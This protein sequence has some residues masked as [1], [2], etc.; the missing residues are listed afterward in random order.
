MKYNLLFVLTF[1][2][3]QFCIAQYASE[4]VKRVKAKLDLV[5]DYQANAKLKT[6]V[7]FLKVPVSD[8]HIFYKKPSRF[9]IK[10]DGG[11]S[12]LPKSGVSINVNSLINSG[13]YLAVDAGESS[14]D[15]QKLRIIKLVPLNENSELVI[16]TLYIDTSALLIRKASTTTRQNGTYD[17]E[18]RYG[19]FAEWALPDKLVFSFNTKD[20]KMPKGITFEYEGGEKNNG[21]DEKLRNKKGRVEITYNSYLINQGIPD[22]IFH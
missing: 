21:Y 6:D 14:L 20:Y 16:S 5:S 11:I 15:G 8:V 19:K 22:E 7:A 1:F 2:S 17:L 12:L 4:L 9:R 13:E 10:K 3:F 18:M